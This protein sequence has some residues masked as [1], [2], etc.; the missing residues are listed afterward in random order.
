MA[1]AWEVTAAEW[2]TAAAAVLDTAEVT[3]AGDTEVEVTASEVE[4]TVVAVAATEA[5]EATAGLL[6][7]ER[8]PWG[9]GQRVRV[10]LGEESTSV[11]IRSYFYTL[12][13]GIA[14]RVRRVR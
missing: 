12:H 6:G 2:A 4:A 11:N 13:I 5:A 9:R 7:E 8:P 3:E 10:T 1:A 14:V